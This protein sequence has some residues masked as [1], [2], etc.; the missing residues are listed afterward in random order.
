VIP[1]IQ[2][3]DAQAVI[4]VGTPTWSQD[5]D[6]AAAAPLS[7]ANVMYTPSTFTRARTQALRDR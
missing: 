1:V 6:V 2:A 3:I 5:V 4:I 7:Y